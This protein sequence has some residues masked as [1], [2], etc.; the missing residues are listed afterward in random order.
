MPA[1]IT[2]NRFWLIALLLL[3]PLAQAGVLAEPIALPEFTKTEDSAWINSEPLRRDALLGKV[4]LISFWTYGCSNCRR[5]MP[6][7][8]ELAERYRDRDLIILGVHSPEFAWEKPRIA[9][10]SAVKLHG[11]DY[12]V[13]M[14]NDMRYWRALAN[15]FWPAFYVVDQQNRIVGYYIGETHVDD[16]QAQAIEAQLDAL[17]Q[18]R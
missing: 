1:C 7:L 17:L 2:L 18:P 9:V 14:D 4:K 12:P 16:D 11:I 6:W 15:Q 13:M 3:T 8:Q 10:V 5:S